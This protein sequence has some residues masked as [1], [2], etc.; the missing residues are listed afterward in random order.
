MRYLVAL[1]ATVATTLGQAA[2]DQKISS[3]PPELKVATLS[4]LMR[5]PVSI[6]KEPLVAAVIER[7]GVSWLEVYRA[8]PRAW[9]L[10]GERELGG[11]PLN[12]VIT[13]QE[14]GF[15]VTASVTASGYIFKVFEY[16]A[17]KLHLAL[18]EGAKG[19]PDLILSPADDFDFAIIVRTDERGVAARGGAD[20]TAAVYKF[21]RGA[22]VKKVITPWSTRFQAIAR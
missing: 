11:F 17:G 14:D 16:S 7:K 9:S 6:E 19:L 2:S 3:L 10:I 15:L 13:T 8:G 1:L 4:T 22:S 18:D 20:D 12:M 5:W 21:R